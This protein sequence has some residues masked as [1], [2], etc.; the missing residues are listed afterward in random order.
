[1]E[2]PPLIIQPL[3]EN[4][5]RHALER[6]SGRTTI[7]LEIARD[8]AGIGIVVRN[9]LPPDSAANAGLGIGL[10]NIRDRINV[11]YGG[12]AQLETSRTADWFVA[13]LRFPPDWPG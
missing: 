4:A 5:I 9:D 11:F 1:M 3:V 13:T 12:Q 2:C 6:T 8:Q 10:S 7:R